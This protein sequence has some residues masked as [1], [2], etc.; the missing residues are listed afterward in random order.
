[1]TYGMLIDLKK[2]I[3]CHACA[4]ACKEAHGT[5]PGVTRSHVEREV[6]GTYPD[7]RLT[8]VP[9]L[10]MHC[11]TA[12]CVEVCPTGASFKREDGIVSVNKDDCIGCKTC[13]NACPYGARYYREDERGYFGDTLNE[14]EEVMYPTMPKG[15]V[16]KCTFCADRVDEGAGRSQACV[17][18]CPAEARLFGE[19][20]DIRSQAEAA[21]GYQLLPEEGTGPSVWYLPNRVNE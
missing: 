17:A 13:M 6:E 21:D 5:P 15:T 10:C 4:T 8:A 7:T 1:M 18:A 16:D 20:E 11:E 3:G 14:Y 12:P 19:L 9:M 2:C